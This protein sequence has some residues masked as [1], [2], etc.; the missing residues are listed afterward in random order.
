MNGHWKLIYATALATGRETLSKGVERCSRYLIAT[1]LSDKTAK[2]FTARSIKVFRSVPRALRHTLTLDNGEENARFKILEDKT[3]LTV[4]FA[5]PYPPWQRPANE[6]SNGLLRQ[7]FPKGSDFSKIIDMAL[8]EALQ[9]INHRLRK[10]L[11]YRTPLQVFN[12]AKSGAL[13]S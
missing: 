10:C 2:T 4:F 12:S 1:H 8:A 3:G 5:D 9:K 11:G 13:R 6:N 7:Y